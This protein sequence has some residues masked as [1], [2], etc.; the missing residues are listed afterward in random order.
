MIYNTVGL[1][2]LSESDDVCCNEMLLLISVTPSDAIQPISQCMSPSPG[3]WE[4]NTR[5]AY[6][7]KGIVG[8]HE[9]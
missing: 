4:V 2:F 9:L 7:S 1:F 5:S 8:C 3:I 6:S